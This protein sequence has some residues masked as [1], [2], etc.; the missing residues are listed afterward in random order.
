MAGAADTRQDGSPVD[1]TIEMH[2]DAHRVVIVIGG[3]LDIA[4][5]PR[6]QATIDE[7]ELI[8]APEIVVDLGAVSFIDSSGVNVLVQLHRR[9]AAGA[10]QLLILPG[11]PQVQ[12]VFTLTGLTTTLPFGP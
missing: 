2:Q 4:T 3:E 7:A 6:L 8:G 9:T 11:P 5:T 12:R 1:F 10:S